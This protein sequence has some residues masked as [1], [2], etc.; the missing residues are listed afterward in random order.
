MAKWL[1]GLGVY[2]INSKAEILTDKKVQA[3]IDVF[4]QH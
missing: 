4:Y 3:G 1:S 2:M